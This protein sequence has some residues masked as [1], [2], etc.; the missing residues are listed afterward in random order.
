MV[1]A[2]ETVIVNSEHARQQA[3]RR[4]KQDDRLRDGRIGDA[5]I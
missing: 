2:Q 5:G 4:F 3:E 1:A